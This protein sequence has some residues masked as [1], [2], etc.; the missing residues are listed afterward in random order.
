MGNCRWRGCPGLNIALAFLAL[1]ACGG[2]GG[3]TVPEDAAVEDARPDTLSSSFEDVAPATSDILV[4]PD[5]P[6]ALPDLSPA[7]PDLVPP[8]LDLLLGLP[9]LP[10]SDPSQSADSPI[11][12]DSPGDPG[13]YYERPDVITHE[14]RAL[15]SAQRL[16]SANAV[17]EYP[18]PTR[19]CSPQDI[20]A[21]PDGNLWFTEACGRIGRIT[22]A[23]VITEFAVPTP[24]SF[25]AA[26]VSGPDGNLWFVEAYG[27]RIG[28]ITP[29]GVITEFLVPT[30][31]AGLNDLVVGP[32][33]NLWF[34][35]ISGNQIGRMTTM[36]VV[37]EFLVTPETIWP[38]FI[39]VGPDRNL[40]FTTSGVA[41]GR[42]TPAG[43]LT[44]FFLP[45]D[46]GSPVYPMEIVTGADGNLWTGLWRSDA[47]VTSLLRVTLEGATSE[48]PLPGA[49]NGGMVGLTVG[50]DGNLWF[51]L[52][53]NRVGRSTTQGEIS[54]F[55][56]TQQYTYPQGITAGP[57]GN[58]W[59]TATAGNLIGRISL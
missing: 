32:D 8:S 39:T 15:D 25:P 54:Y 29:A 58:I 42:I 46:L 49:D 30:V 40:W 27:D 53:D 12:V 33:G 5:L 1:P 41:L 6:L 7:L 21:G 23:G 22:L 47:R 59:F 20:A 57:D 13:R 14:V 44:P 56:T 34:T 55:Y 19:D 38:E 36:G 3:I 17:A 35:E 51:T 28:R 26:I 9:D 10:P 48:L 37:A 52:S 4:S 2:G 18:L 16:D 11:P 43:V 50:P 31:D 45:F 24:D